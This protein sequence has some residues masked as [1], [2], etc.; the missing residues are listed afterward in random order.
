MDRVYLSGAVQSKPDISTLTSKG[1]PTDGNPATGLGPTTPGA[2]WAYMIMEELMA[3]VEAAGASPDAATLTQIRDAIPKYVPSRLAEK[4]I[5]GKTI[6]DRTLSGLKLATGAVEFAHFAASVLASEDEARAGVA[7]DKILTPHLMKIALESL[8][9]SAV[10]TGTILPFMGQVAPEG[11]L[12]CNG[13]AMPRDKYAALFK[14]LGTRCGAGDGSTTFNLPNFDGRVLQGTS[15]PADVGKL[16]EASLPNITGSTII[17]EGS[18][19]GLLWPEAIVTG[20]FVK[21]DASKGSPAGAKGYPGN[22]LNLD[23]SQ[24]NA[25]YSGT[26][27]QPKAGLTLLCIKF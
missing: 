17:Q 11:Y 21:G 14:V 18:N 19:T 25:L 8:M 5:D 16:L 23:A 2:A 24:C 20:A 7:K 15:N 13:A 10:P 12:V 1:Y 6:K 26:T 9:K 4:S 22:H 27:N 3:V